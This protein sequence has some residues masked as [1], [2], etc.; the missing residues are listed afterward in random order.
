MVLHVHISW[1][2]NKKGLQV[3]AV[4]IRIFNPSAWSSLS[5]IWIGCTTPLRTCQFLVVKIIS[6]PV[7][8]TEKLFTVICRLVGKYMHRIWLAYFALLQKSFLGYV[9]NKQM[10]VIILWTI[11]ANNMRLHTRANF[12]NHILFAITRLVN[13][14]V[15]LPN[16]ASDDRLS[17]WKSQETSMQ[18]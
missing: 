11:V 18:G 15:W 1:G 4:H 2:M 13:I 3:A 17:T 16:M 12:D 10:V 7:G 5:S 9:C 6:V 8:N 14:D